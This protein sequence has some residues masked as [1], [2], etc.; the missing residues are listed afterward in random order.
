[1]GQVW[2]TPQGVRCFKVVEGIKYGMRRHWTVRES[3]G[4]GLRHMGFG[5]GVGR[6]LGCLA[7]VCAAALGVAGCNGTAVP[8]ASVTLSAPSIAASADQEKTVTFPSLYFEQIGE[9]ADPAA[10]LEG[11]GYAD[12][13]E[14]ED[15]SFTTTM[16]AD[17]YDRLVEDAYATATSIIDGMPDDPAHPGVVAVDYDEPFATVTVTFATDAL[18]AE[19]ALA[20]YTA[21]EAATVYQQIA[22]LPVGCDVIL[23]GSD[24]SELSETMFPVESDA[25]AAA[26]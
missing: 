14:N 23:V 18:T 1:M 21:G 12:V 4:K 26:E 16:S 5:I 9:A 3:V 10:Y 15:G 17:E 7:V 2:R 19:D 8:D 22:G 20:S 24:G 13:A 11:A 25:E 6:G